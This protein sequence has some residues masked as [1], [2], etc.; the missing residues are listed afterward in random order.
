MSSVVAIHAAALTSAVIF[1]ISL[2]GIRSAPSISPLLPSS[3]LPDSLLDRIGQS[4]FRLPTLVRF[5]VSGNLGN[6][7]FF[8]MERWIHNHLCQIPRLH[9]FV[10]E[11]KDSI[12]FFIGYILQIITQ[13]LLHA[14][15]VYGVATINT[16]KKYWKTLLGQSWAYLFA[17]FGS[18]FLNLLFLKMGMDKTVAFFTTML[19]F[20]CINYVVIGWIVRRATESSLSSSSSTRLDSVTKRPLAIRQSMMKRKT[21]SKKGG[22]IFGDKM[23]RGGCAHPGWTNVD[24]PSVRS[25]RFIHDMVLATGTPVYISATEDSSCNFS[26]ER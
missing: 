24:V 25:S 16:R 21:R 5:F 14:I 3:H 6:G 1:P 17:M 2:L 20:A 11:Y 26:Q 4:W 15:L 23:M 8:L 18:T 10:E 12:S 13:H 22:A 9:P 7:C 19:L